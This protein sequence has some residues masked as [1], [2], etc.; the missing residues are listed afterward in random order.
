MSGIG[1]NLRSLPRV[2]PPPDLET[3]LLVLASRE[4]QRRAA[5]GNL[6]AL[7]SA[8]RKRARLLVG[9][10]MR[11]PA[12][13]FAGGLI[14]TAFLFGILAPTLAVPSGSLADVPTML[15]TDARLETMPPFAF[16][17]DVVVDL[18]IDGQG[19]IVDYSFPSGE[20]R[21]DSLG[22]LG[23]MILFTSFNPA[24]SF[25]QPTSSRVR[26]SF[27]RSHIVVKG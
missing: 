17:R 11:P 6:P 22:N 1:I 23:N 14:S 4:R 5:G 15:Y 12:L 2:T 16:D 3:R 8:L 10:L 24:T 13:P 18:V 25:G 19:R 9:N 7:F 20:M 27:R 26:V 21:A